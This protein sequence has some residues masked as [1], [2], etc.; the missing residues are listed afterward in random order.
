MFSARAL[1]DDVSEKY[2]CTYE[3]GGEDGGWR[4]DVFNQFTEVALRTQLS[5]AL[6]V[7][8][9]KGKKS[10]IKNVRIRDVGIYF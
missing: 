2:T 3:N 7:Q 8:L 9:V 10:Y 6:T 5:G 4:E 1:C